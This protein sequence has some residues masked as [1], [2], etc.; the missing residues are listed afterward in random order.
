[1]LGQMKLDIRVVD[2]DCKTG[3]AKRDGEIMYG[4]VL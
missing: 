2:S 1:M 4:L 3:C